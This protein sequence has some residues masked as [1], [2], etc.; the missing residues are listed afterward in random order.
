MVLNLCTFSTIC[1]RLVP[2]DYLNSIKHSDIET[3]ENK[4]CNFCLTIKKDISTACTVNI[5][6]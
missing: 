2:L 4:G 1:M 6:S 3:K 5:L